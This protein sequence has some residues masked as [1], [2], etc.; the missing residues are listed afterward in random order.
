[1]Q[2]WHRPGPCPRLSEDVQLL[3]AT[4]NDDGDKGEEIDDFIKLVL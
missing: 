1:M 2:G 3:S 4:R